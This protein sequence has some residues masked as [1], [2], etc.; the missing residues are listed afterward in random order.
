MDIKN[1]FERNVRG[2]TD[3]FQKKTIGIA[4]CGG[5]GSN[6]AVAL[7]RAGI[8]R[9]ILADFDKVEYSNLNRQYFFQTDIGKLKTDALAKH[10]Q[11]INPAIHLI[12]HNTKLTPDSVV[13]IFAE[14]DA[15][16]E[17]FDVA[18]SKKWLIESWRK[19]FPNKLLVCGS[20]LSGIGDTE[21]LKVHRAGNFILCG[22]EHSQ[23]EIG[24][25]SARVAIAAN[26]QANEALAWL[27]KSQVQKFLKSS[28][29]KV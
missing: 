15:L 17:A 19:Q 6:A 2:T 26:M 13:S 25:C 10:L 21:N 1:I 28:C 16:I 7:A 5:L 18:E 20:G 11:N 4:G 9:L 22:D 23:A 8:G 29:N 27:W 24:L 12:L 14:V 3:F